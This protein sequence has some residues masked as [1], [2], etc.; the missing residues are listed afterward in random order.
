MPAPLPGD[1]RALARRFV[2]PALFV[3][4]IFSLYLRDRSG[5]PTPA[6]EAEEAAFETTF[7]GEIFGTTFHVKV[8]D[9]QPGLASDADLQAAIAQAL[10]SVDQSMSTWKPD[11]ELSRLNRSPVGEPFP[12]SP[13]L[14]FVL[15]L[16]RQIHADSGGAFDVTVGPLV[17]RWGFGPDGRPT[18]A[19]DPAELETLRAQ[20]G[21]D[22]LILGEGSATRSTE[23][24]TVDLSAIAKGYGVDRVSA[25]LSA[26]GARNH[27]VEIGGEVRTS[28]RSAG[29][30]PWRIA[31]E[32]PDSTDQVVQE[33][34]P[35]GDEAMATSGDYRNWLE[36]DGRRYSHSID[37]RTGRPEGHNLASVTVLAPTCAEADGWATALNVLGP[38]QGPAVAAA[39]GLPALFLLRTDSGFER[40]ESPAMAA[41]RA[42]SR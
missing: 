18:D 5:P 19:P 1:N 35:L 11:S 8:P 23:G 21:Q 39:Q 16:S 2:G 24:L 25:A 14:A 33:I 30:R 28:G 29:G 20:V 42:A 22:K 32:R 13:E 40:V 4:L 17:N 31:V 41:R 34:L 27:M 36:L 26:L 7:S 37:P 6:P 10:E 9:D 12:V 15:A 38:E 3:L